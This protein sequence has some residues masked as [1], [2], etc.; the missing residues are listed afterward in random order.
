VAKDSRFKV[1]HKE[2]G[3]LSDA[4]N[5]GL[6]EASG[7]Y[8]M[9]LDSDDYWSDNNVLENLITVFEKPENKDCDLINFN[10][11]YFFQ[12]NNRYKKWK[13]YSQKALNICDSYNLIIELISNAQF[14]MSAC[15]KIIK[16]D[17]LIKNNLF[18]IKGIYGED[19]PWFL[20]V[21]EKAKKIRFINGY[22]YV[23]R[24][25]VPHAITASFSVR[26]YN[27]LFWVIIKEVEKIKITYHDP[28]LISA[29]LSFI[30]YLY[31]QLIGT[32]Y[33]FPRKTRGVEIK[34]AME[35]KWLLEYCM[36]PKVRKVK[37]IMMFTNFKSTV[38]LL[39]LKLKIQNQK[40][41]G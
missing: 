20:D 21:L 25:Q 27:D 38:F 37:A 9:F 14:P 22:Y 1:I 29:L 5:R 31:C 32:L 40:N 35:Y 36:H 3:G 15:L 23:Y 41:N 8:I 26:K 30:A 24:Q 2:N 34:R 13:L 17:F 18:F 7:Y 28:Q 4:R 12:K 33:F 16:R 11:M 19:T 6:F 10:C 39:Y